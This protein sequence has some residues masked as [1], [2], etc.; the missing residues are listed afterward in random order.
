MIRRCRAATCGAADL[1]EAVESLS[2][3]I[4]SRHRVGD[5]DETACGLDAALPSVVCPTLIISGERTLIPGDVDAMRRMIPG[6]TPVIFAR[7]APHE[8]EALG[9]S[10]TR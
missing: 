5:G 4:R 2:N 7:G 1:A 9:P 3:A 6:A 10:T 8:F